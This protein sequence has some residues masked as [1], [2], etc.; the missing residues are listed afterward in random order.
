MRIQGIQP[1]DKKKKKITLENGSC[2]SLYNSEVRRFELEEE[3]ELSEEKYGRIVTEVLNK[4][5]RERMLYMLKDS[6]KTE[7]QIRDKLCRG[8]YP[9]VSIDLAVEFGKSYH[10]IDDERYV[11]QFLEHKTGK[12]SGKELQYKLMQKGISMELYRKLAEEMDTG[13]DT[14]GVAIER[15][16]SRKKFDFSSNNRQ[17]RQK[18]YAYLM[19]K[20]FS[21]DAILKKVNEIGTRDT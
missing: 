15:L 8:F 9:E 7:K 11:R 14:E 4:R 6:D 3:G 17:E 2:F 10:Y 20:G 5:A 19:R 21:F 12:L 18:I 13:E 16:L 1:L